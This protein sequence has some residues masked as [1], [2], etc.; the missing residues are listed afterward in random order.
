MNPMLKNLQS[1]SVLPSHFKQMMN[2]I[3][4]CG[5]PQMMLNQMLGSNPTYKQV[6]EYVNANGGD[7]ES[8]FY[9]MAKEKGV[10]PNEILNQLR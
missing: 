2:T 7:A 5:N 8:A 9:K 1:Q 3:R 10:D 4:N 6:I